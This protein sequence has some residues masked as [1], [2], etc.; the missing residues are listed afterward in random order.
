LLR[1]GGL[2]GLRLGVLGRLVVTGEEV[3]VVLFGLL[4]A[5]LLVG[6]DVVGLVLFELLLG[7]AA[8]F[9]LD[10]FFVHCVVVL[11]G[12]FVFYL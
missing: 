8:L 4:V 12:L 3:F 11:R 5:D 10:L 1:V 7:F 9:W 6:E 2:Q